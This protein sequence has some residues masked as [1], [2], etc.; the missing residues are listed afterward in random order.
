MPTTAPEVS[1]L[2]AAI[3]GLSMCIVAMGLYIKSLHKNAEKRDAERN[4][5]MVDMASKFIESVNKMESTSRH[6]SETISGSIERN[7]IVVNDLHKYI[8]SEKK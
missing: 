4:G 5:Q 8:I 1:L 2:V 7:T 3:S 6:N